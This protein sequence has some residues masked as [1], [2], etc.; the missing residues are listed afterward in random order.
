MTKTFLR[1][2]IKQV[3][4]R[5]DP[6]PESR[7]R[8]LG[9][10]NDQAHF[11]RFISA[12]SLPLLSRWRRWKFFYP[13]QRGREG[14][15]E[16]GPQ[17]RTE[18]GLASGNAPQPRRETEKPSALHHASREGGCLPGDFGGGADG[19]ESSISRLLE[20][21]LVG[22]TLLLCIVSNDLPNLNMC[23]NRYLRAQARYVSDRYP[24]EEGERAL[25]NVTFV[26]VRPFTIITRYI[27]PSKT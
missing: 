18:A 21:S 23:L 6:D 15:G 8:R 1:Q 20:F 5:T 7:C 12:L 11:D 4:S 10:T 2:Y 9:K 16:I 17:P 19:L 3:P 22:V 25:A 14:R 13:D 26:V 24:M 27:I